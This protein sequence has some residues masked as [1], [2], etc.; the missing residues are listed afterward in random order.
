MDMNSGLAHALDGYFIYGYNDAGL[1]NLIELLTSDK[2]KIVSC[3]RQ[4]GSLEK[5]VHYTESKYMYFFTQYNYTGAEPNWNGS[6]E[7]LDSEWFSSGSGTAAI[8]RPAELANLKTELKKYL[9]KN[10]SLASSEV[11]DQVISVDTTNG[12]QVRCVSIGSAV[13]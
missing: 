1:D 3:E 13:K 9:E 10:Q 11:Y 6:W 2:C 5:G 8:A 4:V 12:L 7:T